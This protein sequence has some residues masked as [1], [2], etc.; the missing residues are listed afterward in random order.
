MLSVK[1]NFLRSLLLATLVVL[2]LVLIYLQRWR[3]EH[4]SQDAGQKPMVLSV[5]YGEQSANGLKNLL[6]LQCWAS[7]VGIHA[8]VEPSVLAG[9]KH[10]F[11]FNSGGPP[12]E[13]SEI[14]LTLLTGMT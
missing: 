5:E 3:V 10:V 1:T 13:D 4:R 11:R 6:D 8:V 14:C 7:S 2:V 12:Q 9:S